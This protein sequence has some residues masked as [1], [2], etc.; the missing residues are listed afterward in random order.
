NAA[1]E[2]VAVT[3]RRQEPGGDPVS[4]LAALAGICTCRVEFAGAGDYSRTVNYSLTAYR[5]G[6]K[7]QEAFSE[8]RPAHEKQKSITQW[9]QQV[10]TRDAV[11][12]AGN[13]QNKRYSPGSN[14]LAFVLHASCN[15][16]RCILHRPTVDHCR[17]KHADWQS[18]LRLLHQVSV[19]SLR[20]QA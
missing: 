18:R 6:T 4:S 3:N 9:P 12:F 5:C 14:I 2:T 13:R 11:R 10:R 1:G 7:K 15:Q 8:M 16:R 17:S 19:H 20:I